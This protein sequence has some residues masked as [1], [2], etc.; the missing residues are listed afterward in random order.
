MCQC[1]RS[2]DEFVEEIQRCGLWRRSPTSSRRVE[3]TVKF[4]NG[5]GLVARF[6]DEITATRDD[7]EPWKSGVGLVALTQE[8]IVEVR[9]HSTM[10]GS[11]H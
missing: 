5:V 7:S 9:L 1:H 2:W 10:A 6:F 3:S 11:T 4:G 8:P